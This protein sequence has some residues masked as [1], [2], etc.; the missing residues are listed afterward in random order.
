MTKLTTMMPGTEVTMTVTSRTAS[1]TDPRP[2]TWTHTVKVLGEQS[3]SVTAGTFR[4]VLIADHDRTKGTAGYDG[5]HYFWIDRETGLRVK[6]H[7]DT[8]AGNPPKNPDWELTSL[9]RPG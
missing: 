2:G 8:T 1:G 6:G 3:V 9:Q 4:T 7:T 5:T